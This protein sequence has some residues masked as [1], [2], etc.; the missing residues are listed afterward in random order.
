MTL[1]VLLMMI[2]G[3]DSRYAKSLLLKNAYSTS[4]DRD[5]VLFVGLFLKKVKG[6]VD[7]KI[8]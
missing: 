2:I 6:R 7:G 4:Q 8:Q 5:S 3:L 1:V